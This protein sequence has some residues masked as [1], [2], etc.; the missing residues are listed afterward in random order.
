[1]VIPAI[2]AAVA[3]IASTSVTVA[4]AV[5]ASKEGGVLKAE[6]GGERSMLSIQKQKAADLSS[7]GGMSPGQ[8]QRAQMPED[9]LAQQTQGMVNTMAAN[10][11]IS[12]YKKEAFAKMALA[13][14][15]TG[16]MENQMRIE[17][18]DAERASKNAFMAVEAADK[19][20][21]GEAVITTRENERRMQELRQKTAM[22]NSF[23][24]LAASTGSLVGASVDAYQNR[25]VGDTVVDTDA[26]Y[27]KSLV[28]DGLQEPGLLS[29]AR[30]DPTSGYD[31][32]FVNP[33]LNASNDKFKMPDND[34]SLT[35][36]ELFNPFNPSVMDKMLGQG[37]GIMG[38]FG[39]GLNED[40]F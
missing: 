36:N 33:E 6:S 14:T 12:A 7:M 5:K 21:R 32:S 39:N 28:G 2:I 19:A 4:T 38:A 10:P 11:M 24:K 18:V 22:W 34:F 27:G 25:D 35:D 30:Q 9:I 20:R 23:G 1:M 40:V 26:T 15:K 31:M 3:A 16:I 37:S 29:E 17:D 13:K 8:F